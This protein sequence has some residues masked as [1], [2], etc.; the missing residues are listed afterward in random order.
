MATFEQMFYGGCDNHVSPEHR[1]ILLNE[2]VRDCS[3]KVSP[4][5]IDSLESKEDVKKGRSC[6]FK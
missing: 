5:V 3:G 2:N 4:G 1:E 6:A